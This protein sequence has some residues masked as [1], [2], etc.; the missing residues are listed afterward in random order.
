MPIPYHHRHYKP[1]NTNGGGRVLW[2]SDCGCGGDGFCKGD[3]GVCCGSIVV[4]C[5]PCYDGISIYGIEVGVGGGDGR[6]LT[7]MVV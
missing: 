2:H 5:M 3:T 6:V 7:V 4:K 1:I